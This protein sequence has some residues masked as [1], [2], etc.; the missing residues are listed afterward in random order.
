MAKYIKTKSN[1]VLKKEH[2]RT[3][4]GTIF[5]RDYM[6]ITDKDGFSTSN[7]TDYGQ[8]KFRFVVNDG[9]NLQKKHQ[10]GTWLRNESYC[11]ENH[12]EYWT[13]GCLPNYLTTETKI[14]LNPNYESLTDFAYYG[15]ALELVRATITDIIVRFPAE[16]YFTSDTQKPTSW[17]ITSGRYFVENDYGI[18]VH[19]QMTANA[20]AETDNPYRYFAHG[21]VEDY[22]V[23]TPDGVEK[24]IT[25]WRVTNLDAGSCSKDETVYKVC[26]VTVSYDGGQLKL[27]VWNLGPGDV[28]VVSTSNYNGYRIRPNQDIIDEFFNS[29]DG[30]EKVILNKKTVPIYTATFN[31]PFSTD[32]GYYYKKEKYTWPNSHDWNPSLSSYAYDVYVQRLVSL[33]TFH[34][35]YDTDNLWRSMTHEAIKNLDWTFIRQTTDDIE[36]YESIDTS[37]ILPVLKVWGRQYDDI[38]RYIDNIKYITNVTYN[39]QN[40]TPDYFISDTLEIGGWETGTVTSTWDNDTVTDVLYSGHTTGYTATEVNVEVLRRLKL[41]SPYLLRMKGTVKGVKCLLGL[42]GIDADVT[43][44]VRRVNGGIGDYT[45]DEIK[46]L[47]L[48]KTDMQGEVLPDDLL[49]GLTLKNIVEYDETGGSQSSMVVPW[50]DGTK[51]Y[52]GDTYFQMKGGWGKYQREVPNVGEPETSAVT[53]NE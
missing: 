30:F 1:Y 2:K 31:T 3:Q 38:K 49:T 52:D 42:F 19:T 48:L 11:I 18:N 44:Y 16:L 45:Y 33:A 51:Q 35:D 34:D 26:N 15:S 8:Y 46:E 23:I 47:N 6:T 27:E 36:E 20:L 53:I 7:P 22:V 43:E 29:L 17:G 10:K 5:E 24:S 32:D 28:V 12:P 41:N 13:D 40:N 37:R 50:Y 39:K 9:L 4:D 25:N 14:V 21:V